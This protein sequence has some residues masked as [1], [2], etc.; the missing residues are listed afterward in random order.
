MFKNIRSAVITS[1]F[2]VLTYSGCNS[3]IY[4]IVEVEEPVQPKV[5][6]SKVTEPVKQEEDTKVIETAS[7]NEFSNKQEAPRVFTVQ[8][9]AFGSSRNAERFANNAGNSLESVE[10]NT[11]IDGLHKVRVGKY[12]SKKDALKFLEKVQG[13]GYFDSFVL[14][15]KF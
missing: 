3:S 11:D 4:D 9:G 5:E 14:E 8:I 10:I 6:T 2:L 13:M 1:V 15:M 7:I 12:N